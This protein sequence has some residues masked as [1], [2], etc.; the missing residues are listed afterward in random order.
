MAYFKLAVLPITIFPPSPPRIGP[1]TFVPPGNKLNILPAP[2]PRLVPVEGRRSDERRPVLLVE[3]DG[4]QGG[5]FDDGFDG[6]FGM[7][8]PLLFIP[9]L[10]M[11]LGLGVT[12]TTAGTTVVTTATTTAA[13][14]AATTA[15][16]A[17]TAAAATTAAVTATTA[18]PTT[19]QGGT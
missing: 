8:L 17:T 18:A 10:L 7:L 6:G 2:V 15:A 3:D 4:L 14:G 11:A 13:I 5:G 1:P 19:T 16:S 9:F 12:T